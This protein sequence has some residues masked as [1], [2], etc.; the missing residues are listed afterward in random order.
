MKVIDFANA[1]GL[2]PDTVVKYIN[3]HKEDFAGHTS[4]IGNTVT[5]DEYGLKLLSLKYPLPTPAERVTDAQTREEL[6]KAQQEI[7]ETQRRMLLISENYQKLLREKAESDERCSFL[8][9]RVKL[10][11]AMLAEKDKQVQLAMDEAQ[12]HY[13]VALQWSAYAYNLTNPPQPDP[14]NPAGN[15]SQNDD[16]EDDE[17]YY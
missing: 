16:F 4:M 1:R 5:V 12:R 8:E 2:N 15:P 6:I 9:E 14:N 17:D 11:E 13:E 7:I 3:R 10:L